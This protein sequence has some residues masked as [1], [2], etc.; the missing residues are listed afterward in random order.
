MIYP[1]LSLGHHKSAWTR[2]FQGITIHRSPIFWKS[3]YLILIASH[4]LPYLAVKRLIILS[5]LSLPSS[6]PKVWWAALLTTL[7]SVIS[8]MSPRAFLLLNPQPLLCNHSL[9]FVQ[10][11]RGFSVLCPL[12]GPDS[13]GD[14][15]KNTLSALGLLGGLKENIWMCFVSHKMLHKYKVLLLFTWA[16]AVPST[17]LKL[18][19]RYFIFIDQLMLCLPSLSLFLSEIDFY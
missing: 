19:R 11:L 4:S 15:N 5:S 10:A 14:G 3:H 2:H 13:S 17:S 6:V 9:R 12:W 8:E 16:Y 7:M 18:K 1:F